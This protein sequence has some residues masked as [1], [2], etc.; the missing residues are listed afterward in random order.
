MEV[1][2]TKKMYMSIVLLVLLVGTVSAIGGGVSPSTLDYNGVARDNEYTKTIRVFNTGSDNVMANISFDN[3]GD[4]F[5]YQ[6]SL[7]VP[8]NGYTDIPITLKVPEEIPLGSYSTMAYVTFEAQGMFILKFGFK[9]NIVVT[10]EIINVYVDSILTRDTTKTIPVKFLIGV[11]NYG[12]VPTDVIVT[13]DI[14]QNNNIIKH[15]E[16]IF[17][18]PYWV[19]QQLVMEYPTKKLQ[20]GQYSADIKV[21]L[22]NNGVRQL[23]KEKTVWFKVTIPDFNNDGCVDMVDF[24]Y[25]ANHYGCSKG[26]TCYSYIYDLNGDGIVDMGDFVGPFTDNYGAGCGN[27]FI[28]K[29]VKALK[30]IKIRR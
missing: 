15:A 5:T 7:L 3:F 18:V 22:K 11:Y 30:T 21:Y 9:V 20:A 10:T 19:S 1:K 12:N 17:T 14:K 4:W 24:S 26:Q 13:V 29:T 8:A 27:S 16:Q 28:Q 25:F 2:K 23:L 6:K